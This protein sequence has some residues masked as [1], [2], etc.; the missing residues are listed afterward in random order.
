MTLLELWRGGAWPSSVRTVR[1]S[2]KSDNERDPRLQLLLHSPEWRHIDGTAGAKPEEGEVY[3]RSVCP[4]FPGLHA[5]YKGRDNGSRRREAKV[6]PKLV[7]SSD[8]G[9]QLT[10]MKVDSVVIAGQHP[11]VNTPLLLAHTARQAMRVGSK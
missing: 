4:E 3:G 10:L 11:A 7:H 9:L 1:R 6:I 2:V 8:R 5:R